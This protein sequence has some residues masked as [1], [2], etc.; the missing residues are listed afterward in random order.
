MQ[1]ESKAARTERIKKEKNPI[2][3][4]E[5]IHFYAKS[6]EVID[7]E[8]TD[9]LKWYGIYPHS[10]SSNDPKKRFHMLRVKVVGGKL[11]LDQLKVLCEIS[12]K[13]AK[14]TANISVRHDLQFHYIEIKDIPTIFK[15]LSQVGLT[16]QMACGDCPRNIVTCPLCG[17]IDDELVDIGES[18]TVLNQ[19]FQ[20]NRVFANLPRKFKMGVCACK[21]RCMIEEI[22]DLSFVAIEDKNEILFNVYVGGGL[23]SNREFSKLLG[24]IKEEQ[25]LTVAKAVTEI[26]R[27]NGNRAN[28]AK[29]RIGH[30]LK[31]W[32]VDKFRDELEKSLG[33]K[34]IKTNEL[35][36]ILYLQRGHLGETK[37]TKKEHLHIGFTTDAGDVGSHGL[38]N[39]YN[40]LKDNGVQKIAFTTTQNFIA[41]DVCKK[42]AK[43]LQN[44]LKNV[45]FF[46]SPSAFRVRTLACT[47]L[48]YCKFAICE[49]KDLQ[50]RVTAYLDEKFPDFSEPI[51]LS[52]NG[53]I[54]SCAHP[55]L[56]T[57]GFVGAKVKEDGELKGGF[58]LLVAPKLDGEQKIFSIKTDVKVV[59]DKVHLLIEDILNEYLTKKDNYKNFNDYLTS[60]YA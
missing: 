14:D 41:L 33:F 51:S 48:K 52:F 5:D 6:G 1:K 54:N 9:R 7:D 10:K 3:I 16:T 57:L 15:M 47:G 11:N 56:S 31:D 43:A 24:A 28:R 30:L 8:M 13:F 26:Y 25:I 60:V 2:D 20:G 58:S 22:Q 59:A 44:E 12:K 19:Y 37:S 39:I 38:E 35:D 45:G 17:I 23:G 49:T 55:H 36:S 50:K 29:A 18:V 34:L 4:F 32:G 40:A 27:V 46:S 42:S 53:C 21:K